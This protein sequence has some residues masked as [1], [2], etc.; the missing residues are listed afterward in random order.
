MKLDQFTTMRAYQLAVTRF[1]N[2]HL[3]DAFLNSEQGD[4]IRDSLKLK[5]IQFD[6]SPQL[7]DR[8]ESICSTLDC[9]KREFLE[10][11]IS[12]AIDRA[13]STF[14]DAFKD[15]SGMDIADAF[16]AAE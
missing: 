16:P 8:L 5:R 10:M 9:S 12:E 7:W 2:G 1:T 14:Q 13:E 3:V 4:E 15:A 6:T 11:A